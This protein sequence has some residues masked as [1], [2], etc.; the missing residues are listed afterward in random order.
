MDV[1]GA[2]ERNLCTN[3]E[4]GGNDGECDLYNFYECAIAEHA[5]MMTSPI[6]AMFPITIPNEELKEFFYKK[7]YGNAYHPNC[8]INGPP[9]CIESKIDLIYPSGSVGKSTTV[10]RW[11]QD[12]QK[13]MMIRNRY[14]LIM[15][16]NK[17]T[18]PEKCRGCLCLH[19]DAYCDFYA[20]TANIALPTV[21]TLSERRARFNKKV[22]ESYTEE[23]GGHEYFLGMP[24]CIRDKMK[25]H[26]F[27]PRDMIEVANKSLK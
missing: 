4:R 19:P 10:Y 11:E 22:E 7:Y 9:V 6:A 27:D 25:E 15:D 14:H 16:F 5:A 26:V 1:D 24:D 2:F 17:P 20:L 13:K 3:C 23:W 21:M 8:M 12:L 18:P